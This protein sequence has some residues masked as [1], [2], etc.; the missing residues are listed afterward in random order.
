MMIKFFLCV[1]GESLSTHSQGFGVHGR[2]SF[3]YTMCVLHMIIR[4]KY[5]G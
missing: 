1:F 5:Y 2:V 4:Q 3:A